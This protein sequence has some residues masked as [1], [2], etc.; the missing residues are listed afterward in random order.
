MESVTCLEFKT[1]QDI[2]RIIIVNVMQ[3]TKRDVYTTMMVNHN[4]SQYKAHQT[5]IVGLQARAAMKTASRVLITKLALLVFNVCQKL[6]LF[7]QALRTNKASPE[8]ITK[9]TLLV[10]RACQNSALVCPSI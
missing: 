1:T 4:D 7:W 9:L 2:G 6:P 5:R 3:S 10:F 8:H